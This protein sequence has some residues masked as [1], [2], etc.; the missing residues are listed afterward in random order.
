MTAEPFPF[1]SIAAAVS[2]ADIRTL[3]RDKYDGNRDADIEDD[4]RRL[5]AG[6]PLA[7][8]IGWVPFL[9]LKIFL[10]AIEGVRPLIPRPET[11]WWADK[12]IHQLHERFPSSNVP[13]SFRIL[14]LCAG[15]GAIGLAILKEFP[16]V[17]ISFAEL[18][19]THAETI[20]RNAL[21]NDLDLSHTDIRSGDL[22]EPFADE[23]FDIIAT[24]PPYIPST[25]ELSDSVLKYE[26][27]KALYSGTDGLDLIRRIL[28]EVP[29]HLSPG[30]ELWMECDIS[31][32]NEARDLAL[33]SGFSDA[34][35]HTDQYDRPRLL[36]ASVT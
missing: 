8:V 12:L 21:E 28:D 1:K 25:R 24:N 23:R 9:G 32:I 27:S 35:I 18:D 34:T 33:A 22:F 16:Q 7:Y 20:K 14:D 19:A 5:A 36:I 10:D 6:E 30:G 13:Q 4:L 2:P 31:N 11:E 17:H 29:S 26:P 3:V 15:S